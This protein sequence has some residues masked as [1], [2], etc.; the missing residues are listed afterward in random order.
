MNFPGDEIVQIFAAAQDP[1]K[2]ISWGI[3]GN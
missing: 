3:V 2:R 1:R